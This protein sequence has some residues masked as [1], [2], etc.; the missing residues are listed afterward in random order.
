MVE[1]TSIANGLISGTSNPFAIAAVAVSAGPDQKVS[2]LV[3]VKLS[4]SNSTYSRQGGTSYQWTQLDGPQVTLTNRSSVETGFVAPKAG[5]MGKSLRF[6][7][8]VTGSGGTESRDNCIINVAQDNAPPTADA[9]PTQTVYSFEIV[10]LDSSRSSSVNPGGLYYSWRQIS[11]V[12]VN[13][14]NSTAVQPTFISPAVYTAGES[15]VFELTVTDSTGL[16]SRDTCIVNVISNSIPPKAQ[17]GL[18][19]TV[20]PGSRVVL[21]G[22]CSTDEEGAVSYSWKQIAGPPVTLSDPMAVK[23]MFMAPVIDVPSEKL[24]FELTV[25]NSAALRD[26]A[27]VVITVVKRVTVN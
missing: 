4:G 26:K 19:Q 25:T 14:S 18:N 12:P 2:E 11:G 5:A 23:P 3:A 6:Q 7:L 27:R 9:G 1:V 15:L 24:V 8:T 16:R 13:L 10:E 20:S 22:S 21:D 17:A